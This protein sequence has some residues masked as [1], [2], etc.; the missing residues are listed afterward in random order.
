MWK[1]QVHDKSV[2]AA[3]KE[4]KIQVGQGHTGR[5][6]SLCYSCIEIVFR[7]SLVFKENIMV[8]Y[9]FINVCRE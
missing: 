2:E 5:S 1:T 6:R 9:V 3:E 4:R 7:S 8:H